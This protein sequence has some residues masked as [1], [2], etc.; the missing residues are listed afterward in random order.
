MKRESS[1]FLTNASSPSI[2][3]ALDLFADGLSA[4]YARAGV[5]DKE[6]H[7]GA[8]DH[9]VIA[10]SVNAQDG[11]WQHHLQQ[12]LSQGQLVLKREPKRLPRPQSVTS[13]V[14]EGQPSH[15][16]ISQC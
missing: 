15:N 6:T 5:N 12:G 8:E 2:F 1:L 13:P 3:G 7:I 4:G 9:A 11:P 14:C 10:S 16:W